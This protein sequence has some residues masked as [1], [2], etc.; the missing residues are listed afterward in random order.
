M[1]DTSSGTSTSRRGRATRVERS[2]LASPS[3]RVPT[4][5]STSPVPTDRGAAD[6]P[7]LSVV[8]LAVLAVAGASA[9]AFSAPV[10]VPASLALAVAT[11][12]IFAVALAVGVHL[13]ASTLRANRSLTADTVRYSTI[14]PLL[15]IGVSGAAG[16]LLNQPTASGELTQRVLATCAP[17]LALASRV[18][19]DS[20]S[21]DGVDSSQGARDVASQ[22]QPTT[23]A[24]ESPDSASRQAAT[25]G[26]VGLPS[27][28][29]GDSDTAVVGMDEAWEQA[30][31]APRSETM[32]GHKPGVG[33]EPSA[34]TESPQT[35][36]SAPDPEPD[37]GESETG[38]SESEV[39]LEEFEYHWVET[40]DVSMDDVGGMEDV[41]AELQRDIIRPL[42]EEQAAAERFGI[43]L[44]NVL[45]H[46]PPGTG[47]TFIAKA[48]ASELGLP[49]V[50][51]SGADVTSKWIN[52]SSQRVNQLFT[53]AHQLADHH[54]GAVIF[55]DELDAVLPARDGSMN[56]ETRKVVNEFLAHLQE[57]GEQDVL[58][59]GATNARDELDDAAT[60]TGRMD[61]EIEIGEPDADARLAILEAQLADRPTEVDNESLQDIAAKTDGLVA[62][63]LRGLV[64]Q[65]ARHA[66]FEREGEAITPADLRSAL[67]DF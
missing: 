39:P 19:A 46:G 23:P 43:P 64:N 10:W 27:K 14:G 65:A 53:E 22:R 5:S 7:S 47:K 29:T 1:A 31:S 18:V 49:F 35:N 15:V 12:G 48:L 40:T 6:L 17:L 11:A 57:T 45:F 3:S 9:A 50:K 38:E 36:T 54:G 55:L 63:D 20:Q 33:S 32:P 51:L 59:V 37:P 28:E 44:P 16:I 25:H 60:R 21:H 26:N 58:F 8:A 52:E 34:S 67:N 42:T 13:F 41:K 61:K 62:A 66:L 4:A 2:C 30:T 24:P 56:E